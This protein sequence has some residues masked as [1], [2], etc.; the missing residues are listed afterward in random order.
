MSTE[1]PPTTTEA[2][3]SPIIDEKAAPTATTATDPVAPTPATVSS[4]SST[5]VD[6][7]SADG[8]IYTPFNAPMPGCTPPP[9]ADLTESQKSAYD[10]LLAHCNTISDLSDTEKCWLTRECL[11][12]YLRAS[13]WDVPTAKKRVEAT[14]LWRKEYGIEKLTADY[15][16]NENETGKQVILGYDKESRPCLYLKPSEQNTEKSPKQIQHL[17]YML[18]RVVDLMPA[19]Q[20]TLA[21]LINFK[22]STKSSSP[23]INQGRE[24]LGILQNH[25]PERLGRALCINLPWFVWGFFK[26][27]NPFIDPLTREK[28]KFNENLNDH[29]PADQLDKDFGGKCDFVYDHARFWPALT[30]MCEDR[31]REAFERWKNLGAKIGISEFEI[32]GGVPAAAGGAAV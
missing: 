23:N 8:K 12:R 15:I 31:R 26:V 19:G 2:V 21:L 16:S 28:L 9:A 20:E 30:A 7:P 6:Q 5:V 17:V 32:K 1:A 11:L 14:L 10:A 24:V 25:Y 29:V 13:K 4:S 18:E 27:I 22:S 3:A